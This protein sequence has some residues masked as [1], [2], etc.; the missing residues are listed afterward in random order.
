M[1]T[2]ERVT[3][4][5][6]ANDRYHAGWRDPDPPPPD[7]ELVK[8]TFEGLVTSAPDQ[9]FYIFNPA[10]L[11]GGKY[12]VYAKKGSK[13]YIGKSTDGINNFNWIETNLTVTGSIVYIPEQNTFRGSYHRWNVQ[14]QG[15]CTNYS[16]GAPDGITWSDMDV[17]WSQTCGEDRNLLYDAGLP[18][19]F[20]NYT[21]PDPAPIPRT[22]GLQESA[23]GTTGWSRIIEILKP[24]A[25]DPETLEFYEMSVIRTARGYFGLLTTYDRV[26]SLVNIQLV[27]SPDGKTG[28]RRLNNRRN[29][30][31]RAGGVKQIFGNWSVIGTKAVIYSIENF[32]DHEHG[33]RHFSKR[34]SIELTEL[35][36]YL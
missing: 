13:I 12:T 33:G 36:K 34:Y 19:P 10:F 6:Q 11:L 5:E 17:D 1:T 26:S 22:I 24:D 3:R 7:P 8:P 27:F 31:D 35:Y 2:E 9:D 4:L 23:N 21:R 18:K 32:E 14:V 16:N 20:K 15:R 30:I 28:W 29:F 25:T